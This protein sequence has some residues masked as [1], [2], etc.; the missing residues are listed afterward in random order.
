M[1][2]IPR[3]FTLLA[4]FTSLCDGLGGAKKICS[5]SDTLSNDNKGVGKQLS[6]IDSEGIIL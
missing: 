4:R 5:T 3:H 1:I 2:I 6:P